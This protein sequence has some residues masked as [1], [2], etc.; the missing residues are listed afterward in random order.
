MQFTTCGWVSKSTGQV[1]NRADP[2]Q[3]QHSVT[4]DLGLYC[5]LM[6]F[7]LNAQS[8]Y[9]RYFIFIEMICNI[10]IA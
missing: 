4:F 10:L 3:M 1:V 8:T 5:L 7:C 2:D 6:L 9:G